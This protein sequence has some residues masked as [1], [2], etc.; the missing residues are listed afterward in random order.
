MTITLTDSQK[1]D[2]LQQARHTIEKGLNI[3][4]TAPP[5]LEDSVYDE[6]CGVFVTLHADGLLRGCIGYVEGVKPL[7][8]AVVDMAH[9]AAF[10]DPRFPS[11]TEDEYDD[12]DIEISVL[13]PPEVITDINSIEVGTHGLIISR[14]YHSGLLL[15]QVPVEQNW[16]RRLFLEGTCYKAGLPHDAWQD[17][18]TEIKG[19]TALVF[20][21]KEYGLV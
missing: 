2:L 6:K 16:D 5:A 11:L 14:G 12:I 21:E 18:R 3:E 1:K 20:S 8:E 4:K 10:K 15:P 17:E 13:T 19:F 9:S 7:K